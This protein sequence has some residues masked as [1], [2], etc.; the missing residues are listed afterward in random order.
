M[1][2]TLALTCITI[3][4]LAAC[5][6]DT[7]PAAVFKQDGTRIFGAYDRSSNVTKQVTIPRGTQSLQ[8]KM[9]CINPSGDIKVEA[10]AGWG[11]VPCGEISEP[12]GYIGL[13]AVEGKTFPTRQTIKVT[14]PAGA[15]WSVAVDALETP[16]D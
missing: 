9:D 13:G 15:R 11:D 7:E 14:A 2:T 3:L 1:K 5:S 12:E 6:D 10:G 4:T 16:L 8:L